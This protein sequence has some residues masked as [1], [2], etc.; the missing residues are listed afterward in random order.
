MKVVIQ[1]MAD[2]ALVGVQ[3]DNTDPFVEPIQAPALE[4]VLAAVPAVVARAR[5]RWATQPRGAA[6]QAPAPP[7]RAPAP[8]STT[9]ARPSAATNTEPKPGQMA[10]MF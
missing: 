5:E 7:P 2:R 10:K 4:D 3:D 8:A 6:Y 9:A 1:I